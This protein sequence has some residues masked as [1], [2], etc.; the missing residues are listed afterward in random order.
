MEAGGDPATS[1]GLRTG[2]YRSD[3][4][5]SPALFLLGVHSVEEEGDEAAPELVDGTAG[6]GDCLSG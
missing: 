1:E 5:R 3:I 6:P 4:R 2:L